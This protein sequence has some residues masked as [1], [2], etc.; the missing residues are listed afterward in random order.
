MDLRKVKDTDK[1]DLCRKYYLGGFA[2]L[3][4]LWFVN[5]VW[6]FREAFRRPPFEQQAEIKTYVIRSMIGTCIW[7]AII[8]TWVSI[9]QLHRASWGATADY[10]SFIIPK[11]IL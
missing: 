7:I 10:I 8:T 2:L 4:F 6:F 11:G 5:S 9:F 1:L 3:P